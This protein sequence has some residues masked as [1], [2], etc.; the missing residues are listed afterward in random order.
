MQWS[1]IPITDDNNLNV[2]SIAFGNG[3]YVALALKSTSA[4]SN[5]MYIC[6]TDDLNSGWTMKSLITESV[7]KISSPGI[8]FAN[9]RFVIPFSESISDNALSVLYFS[10]P[11]GTI[12]R[13]NNVIYY[14][15]AIAMRSVR[16]VGGQVIVCGTRLVDDE[17]H[18]AGCIW[19]CSDPADAWNKTD[20]ILHS[21]ADNFGD[22]QAAA[23]DTRRKKFKIYA[24]D[25]RDNTNYHKI[26]SSNDLITFDTAE[27]I[28]N[29]QQSSPAQPAFSYC[30]N[31]DALALFLHGKIYVSKAGQPFVS[32][33]YPAGIDAESVNAA[34]SDGTK[35]LASSASLNQDNLSV[36]YSS[37][38]PTVAANWHTQDISVGRQGSSDVIFAD[39]SNQFLVVGG[40]SG[41]LNSTLYAAHFAASKFNVMLDRLPQ[42]P[43]RFELT[44]DTGSYVFLKRAD[45]PSEEGTKLSKAT[46]LTDDAAVAVWNNTPPNLL[47]TP[48]AALHHLGDNSFHV[49]DILTTVRDLSGK[50]N[51]A[52]C[53][54]GEV[55]ADTFPELYPLLPT[56]SVSD[57][58][59]TQIIDNRTFVSG[60]HSYCGVAT[61]GNWYVTVCY[62]LISGKYDWYV[63][64]THDP[65]R[66]WTKKDLFTQSGLATGGL[67]TS[68]I[69][70]DGKFSFLATDPS[71]KQTYIVYASDPSGTWSRQEIGVLGMNYT[72]LKYV[73]NQ[74]LVSGFQITGSTSKGY[75]H[76]FDT[77]GDT[78]NN[79]IIVN[80]I[81]GIITLLDLDYAD[82]RWY[83]IIQIVSGSTEETR[84]Y[85]SAN[86]DTVYTNGQYVPV[87]T[88]SSTAQYFQPN[89]LTC[90]NGYFVVWGYKQQNSGTSGML[91]IYYNNDLD[92]KF[93]N[94]YMPNF[95]GNQPYT[96]NPIF[97]DGTFYL[98]APGFSDH[99][100]Y[101]LYGASPADFTSKQLFA[102]DVYRMA[103]AVSEGTKTLFVGTQSL[104]YTTLTAAWQKIGKSL[105]KLSP[106]AGLNAYIKVREGD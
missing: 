42:K 26:F 100:P 81:S 46:L 38:D 33:Q 96:H 25:Q 17:H 101:V 32:V 67:P 76:T 103:L 1:K 7:A 71:N 87:A 35:F 30:K 56:G 11:N 2:S 39:S 55:S 79:H 6:F 73:N 53:D 66:T 29:D 90:G 84:L 72:K 4:T 89:A 52:K 36:L 15:H 85:Y 58:W 10:S 95:W 37:G 27:E 45:A 64:Y 70:A 86:L 41:V 13:S 50:D 48:S 12:S 74:Y 106:G 49:G 34:T 94:V 105:P 102:S 43:N 98:G 40:Y 23:F 5:D 61:D 62:K 44:N 80:D 78:V 83:A 65:N 57:N 82:G 92:T 99:K 8:V 21:S 19:Y 63:F 68:I 3:Y 16:A 18:R 77:L 9:N 22:C 54:G 69:Y 51:W 59:N 93:N 60:D 91:D 97:F 24:V 88:G 47:C 28:A 104:G 14:A 20:I 31:H 75:A